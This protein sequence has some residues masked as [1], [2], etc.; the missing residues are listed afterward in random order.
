MNITAINGGAKPDKAAESVMNL[1]GSMATLLEYLE[2]D[3]QLRRKKFEALMSRG[4]T[5][6]QAIELCKGPV[7]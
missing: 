4:F 3:A 2:L 6:A 7:L 5:D 1:R